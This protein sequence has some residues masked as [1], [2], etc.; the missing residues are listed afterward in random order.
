MFWGDAPKTL[1]ASPMHQQIEQI[2]PWS[3]KGSEKGLRLFGNA[4]FL[5]G[6]P[7][8]TS[9]LKVRPLGQPDH[10]QRIP[11]RRWA[12][13]PAKFTAI[14]DHIPYSRNFIADT[15]LLCFVSWLASQLSKPYVVSQPINHA[16]PSS[17]LRSA[18]LTFMIWW[19]RNKR[20]F[21]LLRDT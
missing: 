4:K 10:R 13:G 15:F 11:T 20:R 1:E 12:E 18:A 21:G 5:G 16:S 9:S 14:S 2:E 7:P 19:L 6:S 3:A 8:P 17:A